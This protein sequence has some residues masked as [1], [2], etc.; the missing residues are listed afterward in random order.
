MPKDLRHET[1]SVRQDANQEQMDAEEN[2]ADM[3]DRVV[4]I[5]CA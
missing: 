2:Q 4:R 1:G 3:P 5:N